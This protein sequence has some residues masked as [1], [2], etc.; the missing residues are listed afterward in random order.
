MPIKVTIE[1]IVDNEAFY[2]SRTDE[3]VED[4]IIEIQKLAKTFSY[5]K[6]YNIVCIVREGEKK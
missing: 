5:V 1:L 6:E 3:N 4:N 2:N